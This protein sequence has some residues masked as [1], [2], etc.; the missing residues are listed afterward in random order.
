[1][2]LNKKLIKELEN[3][4]MKHFTSSSRITCLMNMEKSPSL[5][6]MVKENKNEK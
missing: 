5:T 1:M 6:D 2:T 3:K 4:R